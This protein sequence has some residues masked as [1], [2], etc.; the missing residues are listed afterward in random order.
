MFIESKDCRLCVKEIEKTI[1]KNRL[2]NIINHREQCRKCL[3]CR[4]LYET[5]TLISKEKVYANEAPTSM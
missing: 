1:Y 2:K 4:R 3:G 5:K